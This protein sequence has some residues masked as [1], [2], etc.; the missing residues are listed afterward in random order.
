MSEKNDSLIIE[1]GYNLFD[2]RKQLLPSSWSGID[3]STLPRETS[4][5][6][7]NDGFRI[8]ST[9]GK[10]RLFTYW[11]KLKSMNSS[12]F[13]EVVIRNNSSNTD[14]MVD[15]GIRG[16]GNNHSGLFPIQSSRIPA[17]ETS[18]IRWSTSVYDRFCQ[19]DSTISIL[20]DAT[21]K[22]FR[23][24]QYVHPE[25]TVVE[26]TI[27]NRSELPDPKTADY[28]DCK[29][30]A[31]FVGN[32]IFE[33]TPCNKEIELTVD[34]FINK[35]TLGSNNMK[36]GDKLKCAIVRFDQL[37]ETELSGIQIAD[38]LMLFELD[39]YYLLS[40]LKI[41]TF[42]D[43]L[44]KNADSVLFADSEQTKQKYVSIYE[45]IFNAKMDEDAKQAQKDNI[46]ADLK[47]ITEMLAPYTAE[48][49]QELNQ[50]F[51]DSWTKEKLKDHQGY[52]RIKNIV[53]RNMDNAF[54]ALPEQY[55]FINGSPNPIP[56]HSI[57]ALI[58]FKEY[59][60]L[61]GIQLIVSLVPN[62]YAIAARVINKDFA[63]IPDF[64][65]AYTAKQLL[66]NGIEAIY[67]S[68]EI[69][70]NYNKYPIPF[71]YPDNDHPGDLAQDVLS[72]IVAE[73]I[74]R[75]H[76]NRNLDAQDFSIGNNGTGS[77]DALTY[78]QNCDIGSNQANSH[79]K[80]T[81]ILY[82][83][84]ELI[85][86]QNAQILLFGNSFSYSPTNQSMMSFLA[87]KTGLEIYQF[88]VGGFA[89]FTTGIQRFFNNQEHYFKN[90]K[91]MVFQMGTVHFRIASILNI[92]KL[93][94]SM[95]ISRNGKLIK[96]IDL[97][98]NVDV[99]PDF[100]SELSNPFI[101]GIGPTNKTTITEIDNLSDYIGEHAITPSNKKQYYIEINY[102]CLDSDKLSLVINSNINHLVGGWNKP[103]WLKE[104]YPLSLEA[105]KLKI[106]VLG[107]SGKSVAIGSINIYQLEK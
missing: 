92:K 74:S 11:S 10:T 101:Y 3:I 85:N 72:S 69:I 36:K 30:T 77:W 12:F 75:F 70:R 80:Y 95:K 5:G 82:H 107:E 25:I 94:F 19:I 88:N 83:G 24:Y 78:P 90:K 71:L 1:K 96:T 2:F 54:Y 53:W 99:I 18:T 58:A 43:P 63:T 66:E 67:P 64:E 27:E 33:G 50:L 56:Q 8:I 46:T 15:L 73:R 59:L 26:G 40:Y 48:K 44:E 34:G 37:P 21:I 76:F 38:D 60:E 7:D 13:F 6:R 106:E 81:N 20:G 104:V 4:F 14:C 98:S 55:T 93:D 32:A 22:E 62:Y 45:N 102:F 97:I 84:K 16:A 105:N 52:N 89:P 68:D 87:M 103:V 79:Y 57:D 17:A 23:V 100:A 29:Y 61:Q 42:S 86:N 9:K 49:K 51:Q 28:P 35:K 47:R 31:H 39:S 91:I 41:D 65:T